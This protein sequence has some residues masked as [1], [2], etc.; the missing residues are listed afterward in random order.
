MLYIKSTSNSIP[1]CKHWLTEGI[2][3]YTGLT[4]ILLAMAVGFGSCNSC[5][6]PTKSDIEPVIENILEFGHVEHD[7]LNIQISI[8]HPVCLAVDTELN[9]YRAVSVWVRYTCSGDDDICPDGI[10]EEQIES[11]CDGG[12]WSVVGDSVN[13]RTENPTAKY[14]TTTKRNCF[15]CLSPE[16]AIGI[17]PDATTHCLCERIDGH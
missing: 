1:D 7:D 5:A 8:L 9:R 17:A 6:Y 3:Y 10:V 12:V 4:V 14:A 2:M 11:D 13:T 15:N 16:R